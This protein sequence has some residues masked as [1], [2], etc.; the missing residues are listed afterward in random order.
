MLRGNYY[1]SLFICWLC[2]WTLECWLLHAS[3]YETETQCGQNSGC[4]SSTPFPPNS[5]SCGQVGVKKNPWG[6]TSTAMFFLSK[7]SINGPWSSA[8]F[9]YWKYMKQLKTRM[10]C[11]A[12]LEPISSKADR[13]LSTRITSTRSPKTMMGFLWYLHV[14]IYNQSHPLNIKYP[15]TP[16]VWT[17]KMNRSSTKPCFAGIH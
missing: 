13:S 2:T 15:L 17:P 16:P 10:Q 3:P 9:V 6:K 14:P 7:S 8:M 11:S 1:S 12:L 5:L 4:N